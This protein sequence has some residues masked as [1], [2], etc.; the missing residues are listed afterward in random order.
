MHAPLQL[1]AGKGV[2]IEKQNNAWWLRTKVVEPVA[3]KL[4]EE[5]VYT[6][7]SV[8]ISHPKIIRDQVA[9]NGRIVGGDL[10]EVSLVDRPALSSA[11]LA[12]VVRK[13]VVAEAVDGE[14]AEVERLEGEKAANVQHAHVH[15]HTNPDGT[16]YEHS[17]EH[18]HAPNHGDHSDTHLHSHLTPKGPDA[19]ESTPSDPDGDG[20]DDTTPAGDTDADVQLPNEPDADAAKCDKC[21]G[22]GMVDG[23]KCAAC[24]GTGTAMAQK[25]DDGACPTCHGDGKILEN[26]RK[27]PDCGGSG[28]LSDYHAR[29]E[30][31]DFDPGVGGGVD[32]DK[33]DDS[34]FAGPHRSFPIVTPGDVS[35]AASLVGHA[36]DPDAVRR[37]ITR[38]ARRKGPQFVAELPEEWKDEAGKAAIPYALKRLHD[39]SC[40]AYATED[41]L[42]EYPTVEKGDYA[43]AVEAGRTALH[44]W[45]ADALAHDAGTGTQADSI[46]V[47]ADAYKS[48][49]TVAGYFTSEELPPLRALLHDAF[50]QANKDVTPP[51]PVD[52][53]TPG[54]FHRG[55]IDAGHQREVATASS[56][57][58]P[59]DTHPVDA[60]QFGRGPL[61]AGQERQSPGNK[62]ASA[63]A[64]VADASRAVRANELA[65]FHD[66]VLG[67][68]GPDICF[69]A[70]GETS[71][72]PTEATATPQAV[73]M[74]ATAKAPGE[75]ADEPDLT[76][77]ATVAVDVEAIV[78]SA[79][80]S[81]LPDLLTKAVE[82]YVS[83]IAALE[84]QVEELSSQPDPSRAPMRGVVA[85][86][87]EKR[88][89]A[90]E[91]QQDA[92]ARAEAARIDFL[93]RIVRNGSDT[94]LAQA[95]RKQLDAIGVDA[96]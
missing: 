33:L 31:R 86:P 64:Q 7:Y 14:L 82:P 17:H 46:D 21:A 71:M 5:G 54:Q 73:S 72:V 27:C 32:R 65:D 37:N 79:L 40:A 56:A 25:A 10:V 90:D 87:V 68:L 70:A 49:S 89:H 4:V 29:A 95:A 84:A 60:D 34:D 8:G 50:R 16:T 53:I 45:L 94:T 78:A 41:V 61:T 52:T 96:L 77:A 43:G 20:D 39:L 92:A 85:G 11:K 19:G 3:Q 62:A 81:R 9:R 67:A 91:A 6:G 15:S 66:R 74:P 22:T 76:K 24:G 30:K 1:P 80:E 44:G 2:E 23:A 63:G 58:I 47:V 88:S 42:A 26:H 35:D 36:S 57:H 51:K 12:E 28:K 69:M 75:K 38:I 18:R 59:T 13:F 93:R 55:Y 48:L 83:K